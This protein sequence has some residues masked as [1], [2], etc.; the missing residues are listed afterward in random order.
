MERFDI[1]VVNG[2]EDIDSS[3]NFSNSDNE[4]ESFQ[5]RN[6]EIYEI[7]RKNISPTDKQLIKPVEEI[8]REIEE[9]IT[10]IMICEAQYADQLLYGCYGGYWRQAYGNPTVG[11]TV[12]LPP[13]EKNEDEDGDSVD[14]S[15]YVALATSV[16]YF[17]FDINIMQPIE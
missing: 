16:G 5:D 13:F 9:K 4:Y 15:N 10:N 14:S 12:K 2:S 7:F 11:K 3:E 17:T 1:E 8:A 6:E